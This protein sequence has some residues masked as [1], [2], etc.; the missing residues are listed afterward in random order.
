NYCEYHNESWKIDN[1][2]MAICTNGT[3]KTKPFS[4]SFVEKPVCTNGQPPVK[5]YDDNGCC[6]HYDCECVCTVWSGHY[7]TFD[8]VDY[9]F[10]QLCKYYLVKEI[11]YKYNLSIML[12]SHRCETANSTFCPQAVIVKSVIV[13]PLPVLQAFI[14]GKQIY[15]AYSNHYLSLFS[16]DMA[17]TLMIP[18]IQ[19]KIFYKTNSFSIYLPYDLFHGN[20][21]GQ[22]GTCD[23]SQINECRYPN[24]EKG[25]CNIFA[26]SWVVPGLPCETTTIPPTTS[27][28]SAVFV[29]PSS[30]FEE[31][32]SVI[33][34]FPYISS[35]EI[36]GCNGGGIEIPH[37]NV[38][39]IILE[40][41]A[42][43]C[44]EKGICIDWRNRTNGMCEHRCPEGKVYKACGPAVEPTCNDRYNSMFNAGSSPS[45]TDT[46]EGCF[47]PEDT[48]LFNQV[49]DE[50]VPACDCTGPDGKPKLPGETWISDCNNCT[51]DMDSMSVVCKRT[52][53]QTMKIPDCSEEG[54]VLVSSS[55]GCCTQYICGPGQS[56]GT[57]PFVPGPCQ[58]CYCG[59]HMDPITMV[60]II[61][62]KPIVCNTNCSEGFEYQE[63]PDQCC[64]TC[65]QKSCVFIA[66]DKSRHVIEVSYVEVLVFHTLFKGI[67]DNF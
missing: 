51:C 6:F 49:Y 55:D 31:C 59:P 36:D 23:N 28:C 42:D 20:T 18:S 27:T 22:C 53:C 63:V 10:K 58:E 48:T 60:N 45:S 15:P 29:Y 7:N 44:A 13:F 17:I 64:G 19:T 52:P 24:G 35:C 40:T 1:C 54:Q 25:P 16:T 67:T 41:Y 8:G 37:I 21:E 14:N 2:N 9:V 32:A 4:C 38:T 34:A 3:V 50:C 57:T 12:D 65:V 46:K 5:V 61:E 39:C 62:C 30:I 47:C 66:L 56:S 11:Q 33:P 43:L 26:P